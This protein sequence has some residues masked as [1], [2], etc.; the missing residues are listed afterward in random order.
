[1]EVGC[2]VFEK[3][4]KSGQ[5]IVYIIEKSETKEREFLRQCAGRIEY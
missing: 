1:V 5:T 4:E 2:G 3:K